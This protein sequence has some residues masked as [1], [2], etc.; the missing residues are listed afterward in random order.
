MMKQ[1]QWVVVVTVI[2]SIVSLFMEQAAFVMPVPRIVHAVIDY[3][4]LIII[5]SETVYEIVSAKYKRQYFRQNMYT[6][7]VTCIFLGLFI[8]SKFISYSMLVSE[9]MILSVFARSIFAI[10]KIYSRSRKITGY[11]EKFT[12]NPART[13]LLSFFFVIVAGALILMMGFTSVNGEGLKFVDAFFTATS[14]VCVTGLT[15]VDT[16]A[17]LSV[18]GQLTVMLL[19]QIGGLGIMILSFFAIFLVRRRVSLADKMLLSYMLSEDDTTNIFSALSSIVIS[20]FVIEGAGALLL[21]G[22]FY[23]TLGFTWKNVFFSV[24]HSVSAFCNAGF[25]LYE[26]NLES[27][28]LNPLVILTVSALI[29]CGGIGFAVIGNIRGFLTERIRNLFSHKKKALHTDLSLSTKVVLLYTGILVFGGMFFIYIL[30]HDNS[31]KTYNLGEQYLAAFF[32][33]VTLRTAGFNSMPLGHLRDATY[34]VMCLLMFIGA[35]SGSTAGGLKVNTLAILFSSLRSYLKGQKTV[36]MGNYAVSNEKT[37]RAFII[38]FAGGI[39]VICGT[40]VLSV[41]EQQSF[42]AILFETV[43]AIGTVGL[44]AGIT[45]FLSD[46]GN[47]TLMLLMFWGRQG[48]LTI[49]AA[50]GWEEEKVSISWPQADI[51]VG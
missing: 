11:V 42:V 47:I 26:G 3:M 23:G 44:S 14:A 27:F 12:A 2:L 45:S 50:A 24:F 7:L 37:V 8:Y 29:V 51:L 1:Y 22:G 40:F 32:Q 20:T 18:W 48:P 43:S 6:F 4:L 16:A 41:S 9:L 31:M 28:R 25:S 13:I 46:I 17:Y 33:S 35:G 15:V 36:M 38:L 39:A 5:C 19:I 49:L 21:F 34:I 30:E 10:L